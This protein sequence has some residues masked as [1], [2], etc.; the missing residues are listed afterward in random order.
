[1]SWLHYAVIMVHYLSA[2]GIATIA[3]WTIGLVRAVLFGPGIAEGP[4]AGLI[5]L[6]PFTFVVALT[7]TIVPFIILRQAALFFGVRG[8]AYFVV[9]GVLLGVGET[10]MLLTPHWLDPQAWVRNSSLAE[11]FMLSG[12]V[13]GLVY[14]WMAVRRPVA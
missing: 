1:M 13:G 10:A 9:C 7:T 11:C 3:F 4:L 5:V 8:C 12:A 2:L 6:V 14:W